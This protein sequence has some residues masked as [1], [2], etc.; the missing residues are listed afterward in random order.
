MTDSS[1][2]MLITGGST[3]IGAASAQAALEAGWRV[4]LGARSK[5]KL[6]KVFEELGGDESKIAFAPCDVTEPQQLEA[7]VGL[8]EARFGRLDAVFANAG[9]GGSP[10]GFSGADPEVWKTMILTNVYGLGLTLQASLPALKKSKGHV[11]ITGSVAGRRTLGGSMYSATKWAANAIGYNLREEL[12]GT[13]VRV[14]VIEPGVVDTPF[15]DDPKPDGL[16]P[17]DIARSVMY[18]VSQPPTVD[19][20]ELLVLPTPPP[21]DS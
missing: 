2:V 8:A 13:G 16:R 9:V 20:H 19:V 5:D 1:K 7:L 18:A 6:E 14:T 12:R 11:L 15:F 10:G 4:V 17:A 21:E 3:G